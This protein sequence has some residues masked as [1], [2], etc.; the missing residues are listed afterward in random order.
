MK[1]FEKFDAF[2]EANKIN[3]FS[4]E[5]VKNEFNSVVYRAHMEVSGQA[6]P[7]MIVVDDSIYAMIQ[8]R[9]AAGVVNDG[10]KV[11]LLERLNELNARYKVFKYY[12]SGADICLDSCL[13]D[14]EDS[15]EP[16]ILH[17]V[18]EVILK[19]LTEEYS[20]L[21]NIVWAK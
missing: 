4:K 5:E 7:T 10:N 9:V 1:K 15:F 19:H 21:M 11:A 16:A 2:L 3:Y 14:T 17:M 20:N 12:L 6:L 18:I 8:V 13:T